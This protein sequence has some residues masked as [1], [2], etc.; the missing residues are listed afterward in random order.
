MIDWNYVS[1]L[2]FGFIWT[3]RFALLNAIGVSVLYL[4]GS[5]TAGI[6]LGAL[7][8]AT[9]RSGPILLRWIVIGFVEFFRNMPLLVQLYWFHFALPAF[10]GITTSVLESGAIALTLN[11]AAY[12]SEVIRAGIDSI[13]KGQ[14]E[15]AKALALPRWSLWRE[16]IFPQAFRIIIPPLSN[17]VL[18]FFKSTAILSVLSIPELMRVTARVSTYAG[19]PVEMYTAAAIAYVIVGY[20]IVY[21]FRYVERRMQIEIR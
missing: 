9:N 2:D 15:A 12:Y 16:I 21:F 1:Q 19:K 20:V 8:A 11:S 6:L 14:W 7:F 13:G 4:I 18:G 10:T 5:S 17:T 3:Y